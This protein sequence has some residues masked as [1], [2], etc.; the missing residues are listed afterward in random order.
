MGSHRPLLSFVVNQGS[1]VDVSEGVGIPTAP[2]PTS[3]AQGFSLTLWMT[4][5]LLHVQPLAIKE[6]FLRR[7]SASHSQCPTLLLSSHDTN[8]PVETL[9]GPVGL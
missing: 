5:Y 3:P 2:G 7:L 8:V 4:E 6:M 1:P 9:L